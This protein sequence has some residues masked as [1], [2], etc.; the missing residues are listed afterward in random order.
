MFSTLLY[1]PHLY[2]YIGWAASVETTGLFVNTFLLIR[3][4]YPENGTLNIIAG[5]LMWLSFLIFRLLSLVA[6]LGML[7]YDAVEFEDQ[8]IAHI[9][10]LFVVC[11]G[12]G[13]VA[14]FS[15]SSLWFYK[16]TVGILK[17]LKKD[18]TVVPVDDTADEGG[19]EADLQK[20]RAATEDDNGAVGTINSAINTIGIFAIIIYSHSS[21]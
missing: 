15:M 6:C 13:V 9:T 16:M 21:K 3:R 11:M 14:I 17:A 8:T 2:F 5:M 19:M 12:F 18:T 7:V 20:P 4:F 1:Y 10:V